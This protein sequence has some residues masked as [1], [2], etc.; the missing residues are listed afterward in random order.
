MEVEARGDAGVVFYISLL[1]CYL[2]G[3]EG[4]PESFLW[5]ELV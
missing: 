4:E 3:Y 1:A 2:E 5:M